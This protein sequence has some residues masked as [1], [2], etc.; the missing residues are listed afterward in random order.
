EVRAGKHV[1]LALVEVAAQA[2]VPVRQREQRLALGQQVQVE[3]RLA[4]LP[5]VY[6]VRPLPDHSRSS[7]SLTTMSAPWTSSA[8]WVREH[9][10]ACGVSGARASPGSSLDRSTPTTHPKAPARPASTPA[11]ASSKTA[12]CF[13]STPSRCAAAR[14]VSGA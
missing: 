14:N 9:A 10:T 7:R 1:R 11:S 2:D 13:G 3:M 8:P 4:Q 12:A 6:R 5:G